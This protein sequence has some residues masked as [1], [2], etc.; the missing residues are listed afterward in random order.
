[1]CVCQGMGCVRERA[2]KKKKALYVVS[3]VYTHTCII[4]HVYVPR[5]GLCP[6]ESEEENRC[7]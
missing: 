5:H 6:C 7:M 3:I 4:H 2:R 1:M